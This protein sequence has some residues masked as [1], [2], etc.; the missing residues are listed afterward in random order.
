[1]A[2][3]YTLAFRHHDDPFSLL[4]TTAAFWTLIAAWL[5]ITVFLV[6]KWIVYD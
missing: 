6:V 2:A 1:M 4:V 5:I 3:G